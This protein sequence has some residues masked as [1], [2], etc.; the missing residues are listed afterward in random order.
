MPVLTVK[1]V[2][3]AGMKK[4]SKVVIAPFFFAGAWTNPVC[5]T[6]CRQWVKIPGDFGIPGIKP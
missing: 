5:N 4:D 2:E 6:V 3:I 1:T